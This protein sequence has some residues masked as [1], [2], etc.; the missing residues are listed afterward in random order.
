MLSLPPSLPSLIFIPGLPEHIYRTSPGPLPCSLKTQKNQWK[1]V[2]ELISKFSK[3]NKS[4][5]SET[6]KINSIFS[7][8]SSTSLKIE[9]R[10]YSAKQPDHKVPL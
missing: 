8:I 9:K 5:R 2:L 6:I 3:K 4:I 7:Y 10:S 1:S